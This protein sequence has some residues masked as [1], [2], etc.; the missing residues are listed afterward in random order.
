MENQTSIIEYW[1]GRNA[2][3]AVV[4]NEQSPLWWSKNINTDN[5]IRDRFGA[6]VLA[7]EA[8]DLDDWSHSPEGRLAL[9]LLTD[10]FSR[11][12]HRDTHAAFRFDDLARN[13]C[14]EGLASH[15][16]KKLRPI[17]RV[18]FYLPLEHSEDLD[19]QNRCVELYRELAGEV[20]HELK[21]TFDGFVNFALRHQVII[22]R[23]GRFPHR[24]EILGR[25]STPEEIEFL[26]Q[27]H[28]SF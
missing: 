22:E 2:D 13:W 26:K 8:G 17:E 25:K 24:N 5:E 14:E 15:A 3:D 23:F 28:S 12:I 19:R 10:Q 1:F 9:I 16:D 4:A 18:F 6:L 20:S 27:P 11:N 7:A 21:S